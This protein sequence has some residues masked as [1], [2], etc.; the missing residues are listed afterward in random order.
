MSTATHE[1]ELAA[2]S[3]TADAFASAV[4]DATKPALGAAPSSE[5]ERS[6]DFEVQLTIQAIASRIL[7]GA[8][9]ERARE[10][11]SIAT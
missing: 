4:A 11:D 5:S 6:S 10:V 8:L 3:T 2:P 1:S 9:L 7:G